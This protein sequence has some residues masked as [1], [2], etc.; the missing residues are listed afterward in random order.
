MAYLLSNLIKNL[1]R[2]IHKTNI[3]N[4]MITKKFKLAELNTKI[5][6]V[7]LE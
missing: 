3:N 1:D 2:G 4:N 6:S 7:S 5:V